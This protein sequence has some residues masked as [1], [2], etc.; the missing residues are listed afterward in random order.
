MHLI[1]QRS[2]EEE[3]MINQTYPSRWAYRREGSTDRVYKSVGARQKERKKEK[4]HESSDLI[5]HVPIIH[6]QTAFACNQRQT[7]TTPQDF[8]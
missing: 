4:C 6:K 8:K 5:C 1:L 7:Q 2:T 3:T